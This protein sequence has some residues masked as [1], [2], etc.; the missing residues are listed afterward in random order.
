M[1]NSSRIIMTKKQKINK[2][3]LITGIAGL[4][5]IELGAMHYGFNGKLFALVATLIGAA[6]GIGIP[7]ELKKKN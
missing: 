5:V 7:I 3:V 2:W 4:V 1:D 6:I